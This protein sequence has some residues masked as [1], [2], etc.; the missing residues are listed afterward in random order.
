M[1]SGGTIAEDR[2]APEPVWYH[3]PLMKTGL[4]GFPLV[5]KT[6]FEMELPGHETGLPMTFMLGGKQYIVVAVGARNFPAE[7]VALALP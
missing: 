1:S 3:P 4:F 6:V 5:G 2:L 7:L